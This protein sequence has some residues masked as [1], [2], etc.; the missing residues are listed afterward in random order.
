MQDVYTLRHMFQAPLEGESTMTF[1][2]KDNEHLL[3]QLPEATLKEAVEKKWIDHAQVPTNEEA[4][5]L[6][7]GKVPESMKKHDKAQAKERKGGKR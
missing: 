5:E 3:S 7:R 6:A 2:T 4:R 1:F